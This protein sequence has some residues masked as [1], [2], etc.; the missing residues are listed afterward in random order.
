[1]EQK[2]GVGDEA[3]AGRRGDDS[4]LHS[5]RRES[6]SL[7]VDGLLAVR[8]W[9]CTTQCHCPAVSWCCAVP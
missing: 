7:A 2:R 1:M 4:T 3:V 6:L 8:P 5:L 9:A